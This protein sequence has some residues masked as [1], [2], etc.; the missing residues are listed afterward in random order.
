MATEL[1][2]VHEA[3][4]LFEVLEVAKNKGV[5]RIPVIDTKGVVKGIVSVDDIL[6][7]AISQ[8]SG[9]SKFYDRQLQRE[10]KMR[11]DL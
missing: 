4:D 11:A 9:L 5:R 1:I 6:N 7:Y 2:C 10:V 3:T 8:L